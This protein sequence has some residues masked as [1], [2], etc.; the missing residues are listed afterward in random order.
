MGGGTKSAIVRHRKSRGFIF[1]FACLAMLAAGC[2]KSE[3]EKADDGTFDTS[4][5]PRVTSAKQIFASP[6]TTIFTSPESVA[7]TADTLDK[8]LAA[9][10][11]QKYI[12]PHTA[13]SQDPK[14]RTMTLKKGGQAINVFIT[15]APAQGNAT[16][17]QYSVLP[18]KTDLPFTK[19]AA[20]IEY[21]PERPLL[22]LV[23]GEPVDKTLDFYRKEL[24]T[25]GW[26]LW[27]AKLNGKQPEG[28]P[29]GVVHERGGY[30]HYVN[31]KEPAVA[32]VVTLQKA[33]AGKYKVELKEWPVGVLAG[34][35]KAY[36][37]GGPNSAS[38]LVDVGK[39]PR[40]EGAKELTERTSAD[41]VVYS[42]PR[43]VADTTAA[44]KKLFGDQ[45]WKPY[46]APFEDRHWTRL[47]LKK[48]GQGLSVGF[49]IQVGKDERTSEVTTVYYS[50][51]RIG[52]ALP[53]LDDATDIVFDENRPYLNCVTTGTIDATLEYFRKELTAAGYSPLS[54]A[55]AAAKWPNAKLDDKGTNGAL[56]YYISENQRPLVISAQRRD[57]GKTVAEIKVPFFALTQALE[58]GEDI[59][60]LPRPKQ[61][62]SAGGTRG[63]TV[64][65]LHATVP[66]DVGAVLA[67]YRR[68]LTARHW[69]EE[70]R[71]AAVKDDQVTLAFSSAD[72]TAVLKLASKYG[73]T[74]VSLVEH[75]TKQAPKAEAPR[76]VMTDADR[77][78]R[79]AI[80]E[81]NAGA[82][83]A[84]ATPAPKS[85]EPALRVA[86]DNK[87][88]VPMPDG[89]EDVEFDG[90][91]GKLE[92]TSGASPAAMADFYRAAMKQQGWESHS[93]VINN[94]N[95]V[96]LEFAKAGKSVSFT[97]MRMG[98]KTN[99]S[100]DGSGLKVASA[101]SAAARSPASAED[102]EAEESGN[103]PVP[104]RR[105]M[106]AG[107]T[108]PFRHEL[109]ATVPLALSDVLGFYRRELGKRNWKEQSQGAVVAADKAVLAYAA[110]EGPAVLKL[111]RKDDATSVSLVVKNPGAVAKAGIM[112]KPG[113]AKVLFGNINPAE[114]AITFNGKTIKIAAGAGTKMPDGPSLDLPPG[115]YKYSIKLPGQP[116]QSDEVEIAAD[117]TWGL[118]IGP[119]GVLALQA[120]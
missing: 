89:A 46:V 55:D 81:A 47:T 98:A 66:A 50:A 91:E 56:A 15:V 105:T 100:A 18:L 12:A 53:F 7:Q 106:S 13:Y 61:A 43:A 52:F 101:K 27:S 40:L 11:W 78:I 99:V 73:M 5:L 68:E 3:P 31:D 8:A 112:P 96:V 19:D 21:S 92:F 34:L 45:G 32:L 87:T 36:L 25:R 109:T 114:A 62:R 20:N 115:K 111:T 2:S 94:A 17:V 117:E 97:I 30:A 120:Y 26:A 42:V 103:L 10:G 65:E 67:F 80:S 84:Q 119:G 102:L 64:R 70:A 75:I 113:Q 22:T 29:S 4:R 41:R 86:A 110:P 79:Q 28:G 33:E 14:M 48:G 107:T 59:F 77:M 57:D 38:A 85:S 83:T 49:T 108:T 88:S 116:G 76:S 24:G 35:H 44:I 39:L 51:D 23:T 16:S 9:G 95:M 104:K 69:T 37:N 71:E 82:K 72:A 63:S 74:T 118:M 90:V 93:S 58:L 54:A 6:A 60:G 1:A